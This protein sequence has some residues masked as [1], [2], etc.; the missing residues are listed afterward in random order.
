MVFDLTRWARG[1]L[2]LVLLL[3]APACGDDD[4]AEASDAEGLRMCCELGALCHL[5]EG[6]PLTG[7]KRECHDMAHQNDPAQCRAQ[8]EGCLE[9]CAGDELEH[10]CL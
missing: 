7:P 8:Y 4:E 10:S 6:D 5:E 9:V 3:A 1:T 2:T